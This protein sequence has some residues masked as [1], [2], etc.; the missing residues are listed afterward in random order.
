MRTV[1]AFIV[2]SYPRAVLVF[3]LCAVFSE[4]PTKALHGHSLPAYSRIRSLP[5]LHS[6]G[7][8]FI[9]VGTA[10]GSVAIFE[11]MSLNV[12]LCRLD[13]PFA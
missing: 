11:S 5:I 2:E 9:A 4:S 7:Y 10:E 12:C 1:W 3:P 8:S 6:P 13:F